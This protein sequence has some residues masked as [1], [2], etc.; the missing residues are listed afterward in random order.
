MVDPKV[1]SEL[2]LFVGLPD[3]AL[4]AIAAVAEMRRYAPG[5][6]IFSPEQASEWA[7]LLLRG[8][9]RLTMHASS[10]PEPVTLA[11]L[12]TP[13]QTFGFSTV[14]GQGHHNSSA[15]AV[16]AVEAVAINGP[17]FLGY[18]EK[19]PEVGF[20]VMRRVARAV[21]RRL[22]TLR[23]QLLETVIDYERPSSTIP[24]N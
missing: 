8:S 11:S 13:G 9:V 22:A 10:L 18:L 4:T 2:E 20:I 3:R 24:E 15:E 19:D 1:L 17:L 6:I 12:E 14:V 16:T 21:S 5:E 7:F 23:R